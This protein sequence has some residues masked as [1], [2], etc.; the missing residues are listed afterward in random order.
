MKQQSIKVPPP[1]EDSRSLHQTLIDVLKEF[2]PRKQDHLAA[3]L[4]ASKGHLSEVLSGA[5]GK[6]WPDDWIDYIVDQYDFRNEVATYYARRRGMRVVA[7]RKPTSAE[8]WRRISYVLSR[9][10]G[11]GKS[12]L[13]EADALPD[14]LFADDEETAR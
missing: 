9:H 10:N 13:E 2:G 8:R 1:L 4:K 12:L 5:G 11:V 3:Q 6:H 7:P 14:E